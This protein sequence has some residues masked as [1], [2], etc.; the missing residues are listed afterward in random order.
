[1]IPTVGH[2]VL[3]ELFGCDAAIADDVEAVMAA[4]R[5]A[6]AA[7]RTPV[8]G[9][10]S[11]RFAPHGVSGVVLISESHI[12]CHSWPEA[13]YVA[14]DVYTCGSVHP[15]S[16]VSALCEALSAR[17][18][19][20]QDVIRGLAACPPGARMGREMLLAERAALGRPLPLSSLEAARVLQI[21]W[22]LRIDVGEL[23]ME[24][25][26][27]RIAHRASEILGAPLARAGERVWE[28]HTRATGWQRR[29]A[30][31]GVL[32]IQAAPQGGWLQC[33]PE[34]PDAPPEGSSASLVV[35]HPACEGQVWLIRADRLWFRLLP[36][37]DS[38]I[39]A[40]WADLR[41]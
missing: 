32:Q 2:H 21:E 41:A 38:P 8:L 25:P 3:I 28:P 33:S 10:V 5:A 37:G 27:A 26:F 1:M 24:E 13:G 30:A 23:S 11:H 39:E 12:S 14:V 6:A 7:M 34:L 20:V 22:L 15:R 9:A 19:I 29:G 36:R 35:S 40:L 17:R 16:A 4:L 31:L 18:W